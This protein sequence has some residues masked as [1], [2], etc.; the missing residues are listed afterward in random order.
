[1]KLS[2]YN[3]CQQWS[4][5]SIQHH[6]VSS[7]LGAVREEATRAHSSIVI[8]HSWGNSIA[9]IQVNSVATVGA[10]LGITPM[11][12]EN[13][14]ISAGILPQFFLIDSMKN[15]R[16]VRFRKHLLKAYFRIQSMP[17][18]GIC[19]QRCNQHKKATK[20]SPERQKRPRGGN[21]CLKFGP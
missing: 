9:V 20:K 16:L 3:W 21:V 19:S 15:Y 2:Q 4:L 14:G 7:I 8:K 1:M 17:Q 13:E 6:Q 18:G 12:G 5:A 11:A 10:D